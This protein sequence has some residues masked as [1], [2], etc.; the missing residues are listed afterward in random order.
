MVT[1][2]V[3]E[4]KP[5]QPVNA[6]G[7]IADTPLGIVIL[8]KPVQ[9]LNALGPI[10]VTVFGSVILVKLVQLLNAAFPIL[11]TEYVVFVAGFVTDEGIVLEDSVVIVCPKTI[12]VDPKIA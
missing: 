1:F 10:L 11:V 9:P 7:P 4:D 8:V 5:V 6:I 12:T 3:K 2:I